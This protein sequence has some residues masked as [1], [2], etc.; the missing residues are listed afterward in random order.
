MED[1]SL[2]LGQICPD[3]KAAEACHGH[4]RKHWALG[5]VLP[6]PRLYLSHTWPW[7][8]SPTLNQPPCAGL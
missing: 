6:G 3:G 8:I 5:E 7:H 4:R 1:K 2:S